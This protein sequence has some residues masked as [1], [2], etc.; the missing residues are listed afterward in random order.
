MVGLR[1]TNSAMRSDSTQGSRSRSTDLGMDTG[2]MVVPADKG[3]AVVV[4]ATVSWMAWPSR[5]EHLRVLVGSATALRQPVAK[6]QSVMATCGTPYMH[7]KAQTKGGSWAGRGSWG[8]GVQ[9]GSR[10]QGSY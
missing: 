10:K 4:A 6:G 2:P 5:R 9:E 8:E 1:L 7:R 3:T